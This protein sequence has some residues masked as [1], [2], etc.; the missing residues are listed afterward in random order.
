MLFSHGRGRYA[1]DSYLE[2]RASRKK[3]VHDADVV[4]ITP[5]ESEKADASA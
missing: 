1:L 3:D 5:K 4:D 2:R